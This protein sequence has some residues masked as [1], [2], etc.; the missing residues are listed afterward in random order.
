MSKAYAVLPCNGLDKCAG[1]ITKEVAVKLT[2]KS[3]S[4]IICPVFYRVSDARYNK[5]AEENPVI[6]I[7][8]CATRCA[9]KLAAEKGIKVSKKI[10]IADEAKTNNIVLG[11]NLV[12]GENELRLAGI[13]TDSLLKEEYKLLTKNEQNKA[14][15]SSAFPE[16]FEYE[17]YTKDKFVF[18]LPKE[19]GFYFN[20]NDCWA[21]VIGNKARVG[22]T[23][24][25]QKSLSDIMFFTPPA[26]GSQIEQ[27]EEVGT[28][29]SGKAVFEIVCPVSGTVTAVNY[30]LLEAPELI[31]QNP[32]EEGWIA[33]LELAD[34][35]SDKEL[36]HTFDT[37]F[38][39]LKRKVDEF[40]V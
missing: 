26:L 11:E 24:F 6:V 23:D 8:G 32:Y 38:K 9:S 2:Q 40:H 29:E 22:V 30:K 39:I 16:S 34:F 28:I 37:Y 35:E 31:N 20:E 27:F 5:L 21:Y 36:L 19:E 3:D 10:N 14:E 13:V 33:E 1:C 17:S 25:V 7:D 12:L 4:K 15:D 18:R